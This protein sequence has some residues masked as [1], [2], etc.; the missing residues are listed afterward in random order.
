[1][2]K[3][4]WLDF[5]RNNGPNVT[6][7]PLPNHTEPAINAIIED[8]GIRIKIKVDEIESSMD[9]VYKVMVKVGAILEKKVFEGKC[10]FCRETNIDRTIIECEEFKNLLQK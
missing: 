2:I 3:V 7:S 9:E 6:T 8:P 1:M 10:C 5:N 4:G